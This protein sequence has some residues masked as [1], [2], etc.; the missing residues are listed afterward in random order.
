M[1]KKI[2]SSILSLLF[3]F[4]IVASAVIIFPQNA[5]SEEGDPGNSQ[6]PDPEKFHVVWQSCPNGPP[7]IRCVWDNPQYNPNDECWPQWQDF[8]DQN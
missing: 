8:C 5:K 2:L 4:S 7:V 3:V 6:D 1:R